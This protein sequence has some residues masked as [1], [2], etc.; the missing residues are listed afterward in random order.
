VYCVPVSLLLLLLDLLYQCRLQFCCLGM[1]CRQL[2]PLLLLLLLVVVQRTACTTFARQRCA[3]LCSF[4]K[5]SCKL[6]PLLLQGSITAL[7]ARQRSA[8]LCG[9]RTRCCKLFPLLLLL[10]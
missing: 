8:Q 7:L 5:R 6:F 1:R 3:E 4:C 9:F 2:S 10:I